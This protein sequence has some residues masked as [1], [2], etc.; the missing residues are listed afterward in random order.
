[1]TTINTQLREDVMKR[2]K[3]RVGAVYIGCGKRIYE[4]LVN[5]EDL[6]VLSVRIVAEKS[7]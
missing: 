6:K 2:V 5:T 3:G 1:M 7:I 4:V